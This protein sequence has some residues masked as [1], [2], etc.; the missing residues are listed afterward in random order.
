MIHNQISSSTDSTS[1]NPGFIAFTEFKLSNGL[2]VILHE[3]HKAP[4]VCLNIAYHVG[5][6]NE[7]EDRMGF[8]HLFE[9]LL[10]DGSKNVPR[11][12]FDVFITQA[13]G[14]DNAYTTED[15]TNYYEVLPSH[16]LG[17]GFWLESDRMLEFGV[18]EISLVTQKN[19]VKEEKRERYD[20]TPYG[21]LTIRM[22]RLAYTKFP[23]WWSVIGDMETIDAAT[24]VDVKEFFETYY[25]P[26]NA[27]L[28]L[29]GDFD[30]KIIEGE[31]EKYFGAIPSGTGKQNRPMYDEPVQTEE[32]RVIVSDEP[33]PL[34]GVF[35]A[36]KTPAEGTPD[37]IALDLLTDV[38]ST[39]RSS[40]LYK[41][42]VYEL[43]IASE[44]SAYVDSREMPGLT[45]IYAIAANPEQEPKSLEDAIEEVIAKVIRDG[46]LPE[47]LEKSMNK[48]EAR[49]V[50]SRVTVQGKADQLAHAAIF[51]GDANRANTLID[52]YRRVT[53]EDLRR[54]AEKY[55]VPTNRSTIIYLADADIASAENDSS[56]EIGEPDKFPNV[57]LAS[58]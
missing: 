11:G 23:Y 55:L 24:L 53:T 4:L 28:V 41:K 51:Y 48:T 3:D 21:S 17:L 25:V 44:V 47:E 22:N 15:K 7:S 54:A 16:Q 26:D 18:S 43:Q 14:H 20:N 49:L 58:I 46:V 32:R 50:A 31:I 10:F 9:H 5:S 56:E 34:S 30:S 42:L 8:A 13:G 19:V 37:F 27:V 29:T 2:R 12:M 45:Y 39:G 6:K 52:E 35:Y 1:L 33:V 40:R 57:E 38:L 36:Y